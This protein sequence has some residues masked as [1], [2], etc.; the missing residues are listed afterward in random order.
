MMERSFDSRNDLMETV[1]GASHTPRREASI[2][3]MEP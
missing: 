3:K 2:E 1:R